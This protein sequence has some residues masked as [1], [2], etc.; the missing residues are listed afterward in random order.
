MGNLFYKNK[1][2]PKISKALIM[3]LAT[4]ESQCKADDY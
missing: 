3:L 4:I 1:S 2:A